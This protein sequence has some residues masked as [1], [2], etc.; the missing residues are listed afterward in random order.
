LQPGPCSSADRNQILP[1]GI[2]QTDDNPLTISP[3]A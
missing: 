3:S 2:V 1:T